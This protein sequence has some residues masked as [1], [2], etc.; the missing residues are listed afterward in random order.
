MRSSTT[1]L[2]SALRILARDIQ[3]EDG[4]ANAAI[5]EAADR[6]EELKRE[7]AALREELEETK[8]A[9]A[10]TFVREMQDECL[11]LERENADLKAWKETAT[12]L[13]AEMDEQAIAKMLGGQLGKS[14]RKIIAERVP[15][16]ISENAA[17]RKDKARLDWLDAANQALNEAHGTKYGWKYD[18]NHNRCQIA[19]NDH[20][21]PAHSIRQA[22]D[23]ARKE[24]QP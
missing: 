15:E 7:N 1:T 6:L 16:L 5:A 9:F 21:I 24:A 12:S 20:N 10:P 17:L 23:A 22:I 2:I 18:A 14:C 3:S 8:K 19:I 4:V 11:R 13:N